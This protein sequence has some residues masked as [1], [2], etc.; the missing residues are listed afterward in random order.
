MT[1]ILLA[2]DNRS[3]RTLI[4]EILAATDY[5]LLEATDGR[6]AMRI[7]ENS[8]PDLV[9]LDLNLP[10]LANQG[11]RN[12]LSG[13]EV[14][15][16][17]QKTIPFIVL[18]VD[19]SMDSLRSAIAAGAYNYLVKPINPDNLVPSIEVTLARSMERMNSER[20]QFISRAEGILMATHQC[21]ESA[22]KQAIRSMAST[23][24]RKA[25][26][27]AQEI[28]QAQG[29]LNRLACLMKKP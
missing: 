16:G 5:E 11:N 22:A 6:E 13:L 3:T 25:Y 20:E 4:R 19:K 26:E 18:T 29:S 10:D 7:C 24:R 2:E 14:A 27:V 23:E 21:S 28:I 12:A 15:R 8:P 17:L 9:I 1:T